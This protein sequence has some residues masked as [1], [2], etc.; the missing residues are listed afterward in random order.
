VFETNLIYSRV[1]GLQASS[2]EVD[3]K[4]V[5]AH[6]LAPVPTSMFTETGEMRCSKAKS[7]LKNQLKVGVSSRNAQ[8]TDITIIDGTAL[9]WVIHWPVGGEVKPMYQTSENISKGSC[10]HTITGLSQY[11]Y[12]FVLLLHYYMDDDLELMVRI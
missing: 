11:T 4:D 10:N 9:L 2:R 6:E 5:L 7:V 3:I 8:N 1:L 12:V